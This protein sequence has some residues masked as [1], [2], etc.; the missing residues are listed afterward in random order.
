M[1]GAAIFEFLGA[2]TVGAR[3]ATTI[4]NGIIVSLVLLCRSLLNDE[5]LIRT[6]LSC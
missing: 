4:K 1:I 5:R 6:F 2:V 3:V